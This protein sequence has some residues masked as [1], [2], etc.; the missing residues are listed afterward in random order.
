M[1]SGLYIALA[2]QR[3]LQSQLEV[4]ANNVANST[5]P[6]FK[7]EGVSF[8]SLM[9]TA[10][11]DMLTFPVAGKNH[12][13]FRA[14]ALQPTGN[15]FDMALN[16]EGWFAI[17]TPGGIAYTRDGRMTPNADGELRGTSGHPI[18]DSSG[19]PVVVNPSGGPIRI[20]PDGRVEQDGVLRGNI[21]V[22][23]IDEAN[24][25]SRYE[26][27]GFY[28][29]T[30]AEPLVPGAGTRIAQGFVE[31][32]NVDPVMETAR[33]MQVMTMFQSISAALKDAESAVSR[34]VRDMNAT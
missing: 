26:N 13:D 18:L 10:E 33:L 29:R 12:T 14:G 30:E 20:T 22:F 2:G 25:T 32:S 15:D 4:V 31:A 23:T 16:G 5:T 19:S 6:G 1:Q 21:G 24:F 3:T 27:S 7:A 8:R 17:Q 9:S 28:A 11:E 34:S